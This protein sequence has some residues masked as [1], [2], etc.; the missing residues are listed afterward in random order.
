[1]T[2]LRPILPTLL[3]S[4]T[5]YSATIAAS[6]QDPADF[7]KARHDKI[8][9]AIGAGETILSADDRERLK[10][11]LNEAINFIELSRRSLGSYWTPL[12]APQRVEFVGVLS[13]IIKMNSIKN[14]SIYRT[15]TVTYEPSQVT[16]NIAAI[17]THVF[18][19]DGSDVVVRYQLLNEGNQWKIFDI[20]IDDVSTIENYQ[21]LF[22]RT[23]SK[24]SYAG[25]LK[26]LKTKRDLLRSE[27]SGTGQNA[28][29]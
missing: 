13:D 5:L 2:L 4:L 20:I 19:D 15:T 29:H 25:L 17:V 7:L 24:S 22:N 12:T 23:I 21:S 1:M 10:T 16:G 6:I 27:E 14:L 8:R 9:E 28:A 11:V 18:T 26:K 3:V